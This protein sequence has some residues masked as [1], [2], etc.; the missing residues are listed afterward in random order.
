MSSIRLDIDGSERQ[1]ARRRTLTRGVGLTVA[2]VLVLGGVLPWLVST[3]A[4]NALVLRAVN[5]RIA[6]TVTVAS[7]ETGWLSGTRVRGLRLLDPE[8]VLV[9]RGLDADADLGFGGLLL[10]GRRSGWPAVDA[11]VRVAEVDLRR[12]GAGEL[13]LE[14]SLRRPAAVSG[15]AEPVAAGAPLADAAIPAVGWRERI[16]WT[17]TGIATPAASRVSLSVGSLQLH[18]AADATPSRATGVVLEVDARD[19][20]RISLAFGGELRRG[21]RAGRLD[22]RVA[23]LQAASGTGELRPREAGVEATAKLD[24]VP[25]ALLAAWAGAEAWAWAVPA[26]GETLSGTLDASGTLASPRGRVTLKSST[27]DARLGL[28]ADAPGVVATAGSG[29]TWTL[30]PEAFA[31]LVGGRGWSLRD[32]ATLELAV[33]RLRIPEGAAGSQPEWASTRMVATSGPIRLRSA[34]GPLSLNSGSLLLSSEALGRRVSLAVAA[35]AR[36]GAETTPVRLACVLENARSAEVDGPPRLT[37]SVVGLPS[38]LLTLLGERAAGF[39]RLLGPVLALEVDAKQL[40]PEGRLRLRPAD[41]LVEARFGSAGLNGPLTL[42]FGDGGDWGSISTPEPLRLVLPAATATSPPLPGW[43][44][45]LRPATPLEATLEIAGLRWRRWV[46]AARGDSEARPEPS[47]L[48]LEAAT[49]G[50]RAW[51]RGF[52]PDGT[53]FAGVL[54][55]PTADLVTGAGETLHLTD[56]LVDVAAE[57]LGEQPEAFATARLVADESAAGSDGAVWSIGGAS[58]GA[59]RGRFRVTSLLDPA[60]RFRPD[61]ALL[62]GDALGEGL[63]VATLDRLL[64]VDDRLAAVLG[65]S[66]RAGLTVEIGPG[67]PPLF[68]ATLETRNLVAGLSADLIAGELTLR[69]DARMQLQLD[70]TGADAL[71]GRLHPLSSD[72]LRSVPGSPVTLRPRAGGVLRPRAGRAGWLP[73]VDGASLDAG[74]LELSGGGWLARSLE[75]LVGQRVPDV[76]GGF[77]ETLVLATSPTTLRFDG[78]RIG[79]GPL[80]LWSPRLAVALA[81]DAGG[82]PIR[83][84]DE[85]AMVLA[86]PGGTLRTADPRLDRLPAGA[87]FVLPVGG[88][89]DTPRV[90]ADALATEL[91]L[92]GDGAGLAV[93]AADPERWPLPAAV[94]LGLPGFRLVR[95]SPIDASA[96]EEEQAALPPAEARGLGPAAGLRSGG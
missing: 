55:V 64:G 28:R 19:R 90:D 72:L 39:S 46:G 81:G 57:R 21:D 86:V 11:A 9:L 53:G 15:P 83:A 22:A 40:T 70:A 1:A 56:V 92:A 14:R 59:V 87:V 33:D 85:I 78:V 93:D 79:H 35:E 49:R 95:E 7:A 71:R 80:W 75:R 16:G 31:A 61:L 38:E 12:T 77:G 32:P 29:V 58:G 65:P 48:G 27:L 18:D 13:N 68:S 43:L 25:V 37:A 26:L 42:R 54:R 76:T 44:A 17:G 51:L 96:R 63:S 4:G 84:D 6:G 62:R 89:L 69:P 20:D 73:L 91:L 34:A 2:G 60:D 45:G 94:R 67:Q 41:A 36:R 24:A 50:P 47:G 52:D 66:L 82:G 3:A 5:A 23:L 10:A 30:S 74:R 88:P 8:G